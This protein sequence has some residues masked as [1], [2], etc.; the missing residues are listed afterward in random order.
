MAII[1]R[2]QR[3]ALDNV[4]GPG[5]LDSFVG[6]FF[7]E[8]PIKQFPSVLLVCTG[9]L[10]AREESPFTRTGIHRMNLAVAMQSQQAE[11][12][13]RAVIDYMEAVNQIL[14]SIDPADYTAGLLL[15]HPMFSGGSKVLSGIGSHM[16]VNSLVVLTHEY[17]ELLNTRDG[18]ATSGVITFEVETEE[19]LN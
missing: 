12:C 18:F 5:G 17:A 2:H 13:A 7:A 1:Q 8:V 14:E 4:A 15:S 19:S 6:Y 9:T 11:P 10:W 3:A 16:Q